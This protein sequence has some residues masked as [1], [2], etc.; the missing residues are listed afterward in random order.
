MDRSVLDVCKI[1]S[2]AWIIN[3]YARLRDGENAYMFD[4]CPPFQI[5]GN[6]GGAAGVADMVWKDG[7]VG[8]AAVLSR[9][10][11]RLTV[12]CHSASASVSIV[13]S[14]TY[15]TTPGQNVLF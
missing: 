4:S 12:R 9:L 2:R 13:K 5:D 14:V 1:W 11:G 7:V 8:N 15:D 3:Y 6:F 10:G